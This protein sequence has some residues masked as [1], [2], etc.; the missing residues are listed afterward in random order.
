MREQIP[1]WPHKV[2][3]RAEIL[4]NLCAQNPHATRREIEAH[5]VFH[6]AI[7]DAPS[8]ARKRDEHTIN[9]LVEI[10]SRDLHASSQGLRS[11]IRKW[12]DG[13]F[14]STLSEMVLQGVRIPL[15]V[16]EKEI[17]SLGSLG[18][19]TMPSNGTVAACLV[20]AAVSI[21]DQVDGAQFVYG[22][23]DLGSR[24]VESQ[25][26]GD[27]LRSSR[28]SS[29]PPST[30]SNW[31][32]G[33]FWGPA[34]ADLAATNPLSYAELLQADPKLAKSFRYRG[35]Y[36]PSH[37]AEKL[38][39]KVPSTVRAAGTDEIKHYLSTRDASHIE[40]KAQGG[41]NT[42]EN[43]VFEDSQLNRGRNYDHKAGRRDTPHMT[44]EELEAVNAANRS[45]QLKNAGL[46]ALESGLYAAGFAAALEGSLAFLEESVNYRKGE[47]SATECA[48][49][50]V[51]KA[52]TTGAVGGATTGLCTFAAA[53]SP[54]AAA[55]IPVVFAPLIVFAAFTI[56]TRAKKAIQEH[57]SI[58]NDK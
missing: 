42:A 52:A 55:V 17:S 48:Q 10:F 24:F 4:E 7:R 11:A 34:M 15:D 22:G 3:A 19:A 46:E 1:E 40:A 29:Y 23:V 13:G 50:V 47:I 53:L 56:F 12:L 54:A 36:K 14:T 58:S 41:P 21:R 33:A 57:R 20:P 25:F 37:E 30:C 43:M 9:Q 16:F 45:L 5:H 51:T 39:L 6:D 38:Y 2:E 26:G 18:A 44:P 35:G 31:G 49:R 28:S 8:R 32:V 27:W